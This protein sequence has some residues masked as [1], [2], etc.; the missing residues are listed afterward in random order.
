MTQSVEVHIENPPFVSSG[1]GLGLQHDPDYPRGE[2]YEH[3]GGGP[4]YGVFVGFMPALNGMPT[5]FCV[6]CNS[7][8]E[9]PPLWLLWSRVAATIGNG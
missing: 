4:G 5:A 1:C 2:I 7:S 3:G 9:G 6:M 8:M